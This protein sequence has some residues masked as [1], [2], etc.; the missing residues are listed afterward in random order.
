M[1]ETFDSNLRL[2][3]PEKSPF[4]DVASREISTA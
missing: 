2:A 3:H 4:R 1:G